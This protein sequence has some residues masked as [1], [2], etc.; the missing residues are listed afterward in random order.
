MPILTLHVL[1]PL[2]NDSFNLWIMAMVNS[3]VLLGAVCCGG[4][5]EEGDDWEDKYADMRET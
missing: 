4:W 1:I 5:Y 2:V 3:L